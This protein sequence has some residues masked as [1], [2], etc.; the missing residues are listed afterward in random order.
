LPQTF[1]AAQANSDPDSG[2]WFCRHMPVLCQN[3][4]MAAD[5]QLSAGARSSAGITDEA[6]TVLRSVQAVA[7]TMSPG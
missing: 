2:D 6:G 7:S 1:A 4:L 3:S 5:Q